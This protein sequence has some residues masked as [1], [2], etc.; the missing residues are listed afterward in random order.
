MIN[1]NNGGNI[2]TRDKL[3]LDSVVMDDALRGLDS[4][5][6]VNLDSDIGVTT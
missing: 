6:V 5:E 1:D 3:E 2:Q 4:T